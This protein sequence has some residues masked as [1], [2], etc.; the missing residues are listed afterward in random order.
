[1]DGKI[2]DGQQNLYMTSAP[3]PAL[4]QNNVT[5]GVFCVYSERSLPNLNDTLW[6]AMLLIQ[7]I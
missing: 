5:L 1:M 6:C 2:P 4:G 7:D 3:P